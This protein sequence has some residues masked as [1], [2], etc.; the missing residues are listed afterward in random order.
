MTGAS[1]MD[2]DRNGRKMPEPKEGERDHVAAEGRG[3]T[4]RRRRRWRLEGGTFEE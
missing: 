3:G 2:E 4:P 1:G